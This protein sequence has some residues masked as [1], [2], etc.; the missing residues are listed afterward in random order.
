MKHL[1][2]KAIYWYYIIGWYIPRYVLA[3]VPAALYGD[4]S[5]PKIASY[6]NNTLIIG[7]KDWITIEPD[8]IAKHNYSLTIQTLSGIDELISIVTHKYSKKEPFLCFLWEPHMLTTTL[9]LIR[10]SYL[11]DCE[12]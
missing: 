3:D 1:C 10:V 7:D 12:Y 6:F 8:I 2:L 9:D 5:D 11:D 4:F